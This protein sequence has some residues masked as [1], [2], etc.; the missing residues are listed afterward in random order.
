M[1]L[2]LRYKS[3]STVKISINEALEASAKK[4]RASMIKMLLDSGESTSKSSLAN[5]IRYSIQKDNPEALIHL[6]N[7]LKQQSIINDVLSRV[8]YQTFLRTRPKKCIPLILE[9]FSTLSDF[10]PKCFFSSIAKYGD[11]ECAKT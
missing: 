8:N 1:N 5:A 7:S 9:L 6:F 11:V 4:G 2:L 10:N 3:K